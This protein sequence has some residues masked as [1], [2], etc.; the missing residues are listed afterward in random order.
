MGSNSSQ[1]GYHEIDRARVRFRVVRTLEIGSRKKRVVRRR[2]EERFHFPKA[3]VARSG[4]E[5]LSKGEG[6]NSKFI[7]RNNFYICT[8]ITNI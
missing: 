6:K 7:L 2:S 4:S 5:S 8:Y 1:T 3:Q